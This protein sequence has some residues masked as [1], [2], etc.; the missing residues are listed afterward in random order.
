V[1]GPSGRE[2]FYR[3]PRHNR[4]MVVDIRTSP[5]LVV[6]RPRPLFELSG[7]YRDEFDIAPDGKRFVMVKVNQPQ[8][9]TH[10]NIVV[11]WFEELNRRVP[12]GNP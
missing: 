1:W 10:I 6:G 5:R 12:N 2:L 3:E 11:N 8:P 7:R 9:P 4:I